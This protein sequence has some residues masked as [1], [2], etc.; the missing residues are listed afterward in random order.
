[1]KAP[2]LG[3]LLADILALN[4][5]DR[6]KLTK[7]R[8]SEAGSSDFA[9]VF[10]TI[11]KKRFS[12]NEGGS[13]LTLTQVHDALDRIAWSKDGS[14]SQAEQ[15]KV[16]LE[17]F[18]RGKLSSLEGKWLVRVILKNLELGLSRTAVMKLLH[19][20]AEAAYERMADFKQVIDFVF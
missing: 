16:F 12:E 1:M 19:P 17:L 9:S 5:E 4:Q 14:T 15:K 18:V 8:E 7:Y 6:L 20:Q 11:V 10:A 2:T 3:K 13:E